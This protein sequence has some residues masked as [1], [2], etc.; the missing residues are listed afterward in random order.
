VSALCP[1]C[2]DYFTAVARA[3]VDVLG[4]HRV[5]EADRNVAADVARE[6]IEELRA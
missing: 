3:A 5:S 4:D 6:A 1:E 2:R